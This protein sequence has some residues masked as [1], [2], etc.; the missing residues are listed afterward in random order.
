[1][2]SFQLSQDSL[3]LNQEKLGAGMFHNVNIMQIEGK[4]FAVKEIYLNKFSNSIQKKELLRILNLEYETLKEDLENVV[5]C[6]GYYYDEEKQVF[7]LSLDYFEQNLTRYISENGPL[8]LETLTAI[9]QDIIN[10]KSLREILTL[11]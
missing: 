2:T 11:K 8:P 9:L 4:K 10:G 7:K 1:M 6:Y 3:C 5:K